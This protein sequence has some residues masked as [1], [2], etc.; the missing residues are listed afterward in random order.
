[1]PVSFSSTC[2]HWRT[3]EDSRRSGSRRWIG[4]VSAR[5]REG[6]A[7]RPVPDGRPAVERVE[8]GAEGDAEHREVPLVD[9]A[10]LELTSQ[11]REKGPPVSTGRDHQ[12]W[13]LDPALD[14]LDG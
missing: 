8:D 3:T 9:T 1:M 12:R 4:G 7:A 6:S 10:V 13:D 5:V 14:H 11:L 2:L